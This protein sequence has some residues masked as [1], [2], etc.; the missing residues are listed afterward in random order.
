MILPWMA[1]ATAVAL[2]LGLAALVLERVVRLRGGPVRGLWAGALAGSLLVPALAAIVPALPGAGGPIAAPSGVPYAA[3]ATGAVAWRMDPGAVVP[4][5]GA[6]LDDVLRAGWAVASAAVLL[7]L[8]GSG[9]TLRRRA[10]GWRRR[11]V[12]GVGVWVAPDA[13]PA[14]TGFVRP[15]IVLPEWIVEGG[16]AQRA[17]VLAHETE[18]LRAG[19]PRLLLGALLVAAA[20]PWNPAVWWQVWRL[21]GAVEIDCD[22]RVLGGGADARAYGRLLL[23]V[24]GQG[25]PHRLVVASLGASHSSLE[26]RI[27]LM[28]TPRP[29]SWRTRASAA[30]AVAAALVL[31]AC[32]AARPAP[33]A[34][35]EGLDLRVQVWSLSRPGFPPHPRDELARILQVAKGL[36]P[37]ALEEA[38]IG[39]T[40]MLHFAIQ[41]G[42]AV[43]ASS[44]RVVGT[45]RRDEAPRPELVAASTA[46]V[47]QLAFERA[48]DG[49]DTGDIR[50]EMAITW[51]PDP[52]RR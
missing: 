1:Y 16:P 30:T 49:G 42:G 19:D 51:L 50:A 31:T 6:G 9:L 13:G 24:A 38:G 40:V 35:R 18:H 28:L 27:R 25:A 23:D 41:P 45:R 12:D 4:R 44:I 20:L 21:R 52:T 36:Y 14:V 15:R 26:R 47:R 17:L 22:T 5:W 7:A 3:S 43:D 48:A 46:L 39:G 10:R 29:R 11:T 33:E 2:L 32:L 8:L 34:P 37:P